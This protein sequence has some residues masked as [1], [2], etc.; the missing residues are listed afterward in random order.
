[1]KVSPS[2]LY[3]ATINLISGALA[4]PDIQWPI[5]TESIK[6]YIDIAK[7]TASLIEDDDESES[8]LPSPEEV[9]K[10]MQQIF[11]L[12]NNRPSTKTAI[13]NALMLKGKKRNVAEYMVS[14]AEGMEIIKPQQNGNRI[15]YTLA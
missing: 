13:V 4:D 1:M 14:K 10:C 7:R 3:M 8:N 6:T 11:K 2:Q 5:T 12:F 9:K 15:D